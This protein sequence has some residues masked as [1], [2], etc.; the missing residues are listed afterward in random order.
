MVDSTEERVNRAGQEQRVRTGQGDVHSLCFP[1]ETFDLVLAIG[2]LPWLPSIEQP[3]REMAR[4]LKPG[5]ILSRR[6]IINCRSD[7]SLNH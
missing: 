2:V 7:G 3:L 6:L 4:V 5:V 1:N